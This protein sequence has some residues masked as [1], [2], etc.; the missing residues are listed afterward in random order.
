MSTPEF[1]LTLREKIGQEP[2]WLM[3]VTAVVLK[4]QQV[5]LVQRADN[6]IWS[7]VTGIIDPGEEPADAAAREVLEEADIVAVPEQLVKVQATAPMVHANGDQAQY[8]DFVFR[9]RWVSG[10]PYP[11]DGENL[12]AQ[13]FDLDDL[14]Q[15]PDHLRARIDA[16]LQ[17]S[18][19]TEF[20]FQGESLEHKA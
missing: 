8:L 11:A 5:L 12:L 13:W 20:F 1:I 3:G 9:F 16:A 6:E 14:P 10:I 18:P 4:D 2:L 15:M 17:D 19:T 7:P